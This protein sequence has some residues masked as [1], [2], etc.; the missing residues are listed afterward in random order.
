MYNILSILTIQK[1][2]C[3]KDDSVKLDEWLFTCVLLL[4]MNSKDVARQAF[5]TPQPTRNA[6]ARRYDYEDIKVM[7]W[8]LLM[9]RLVY[10]CF[11]LSSKSM[12]TLA[13]DEKKNQFNNCLRPW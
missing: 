1:R 11:K 4:S 13:Y 9:I 6:R 8:F 7:K 10:G 2:N 5:P 12:V 3:F